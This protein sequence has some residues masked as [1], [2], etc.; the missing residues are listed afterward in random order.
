MLG[1]TSV[2]PHHQV[3]ADLE[4]QLDG[5]IGLTGALDGETGAARAAFGQRPCTEILETGIDARQ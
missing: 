1:R 5:E 3:A 2:P 4:R